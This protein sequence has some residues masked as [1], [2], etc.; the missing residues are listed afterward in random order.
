MNNLSVLTRQAFEQWWQSYGDTNNRV[1]RYCQLLLMTSILFLSLTSAGIQQLLW[2][3]ME[4][5]L[6]ADLVISHSSA[7]PAE[8]LKPLAAMSLKSSASQLMDITLTHHSQWQPVQLKV[9]DSAYPL[10]GTLRVT[11]EVGGIEV[12]A[13]ELPAAD[14]IWLDSRTFA[15]LQVNI[16]DYLT[17][18]GQR[19]RVAAI[20]TH[21]PDRLME[22]HSVDHRALVSASVS[23]N[24]FFANTEA[25]YR[26]S[27]EVETVNLTNA[28][29]WANAN[30]GYTQVL[31]ASS[32]HPLANFWKRV[33]NFFGLVMVVLFFMAAITF[34][35]SGKRQLEQ[36]L[37][38]F[39]L[40]L[41][42]GMSRRSG[43]FI[44]CGQWLIGFVT[45]VVAATSVAYCAY[46]LVLNKFAGHFA[47]LDLSK[48]TELSSGLFASLP[49][50]PWFAWGK[51][52]ALLAVLLLLF[53]AP[54]WLKLFR[55]SPAI[56]LKKSF[57]GQS[58]LIVWL[59]NTLVI[60][61]LAF[62]YS[63]N[64]LLT[65]M[66][67]SGLAA[68]LV[69]MAVVTWLFLSFG[70]KITLAR[71]SLLV[72]CLGLMKQRMSSKATQIMGLGLCITLMLFSFGLMRDF[73]SMLQR[74]TRTH[75]GNL[76]ISQV[77]QAQV[78]RLQDWADVN[79]ANI[80]VLKPYY[81]A[82]LERINGLT[83]SDAIKYPSEASATVQKPVRLHTTNALPANNTVE[84]GE[85]WN[86]GLGALGDI[87]VE[88]EVMMDLG[89]S[90]G[91]T[92]QFRLGKQRFTFTIRASHVFKA[93]RDSV[94]FWFQVPQSVAAEVAQAPMFMGSME[95]PD[96]AWPQLAELWREMPTLKML[97]LKEIAERFD[98]ILRLMQLT[99][100]LFS[101]LILLLSLL[102]VVS[103]IQGFQAQDKTRNGLMLSFGMSKRECVRLVAWE[104]LV[105]GL[106]AS[107]SAIIGT[108]LIGHLMYQSQFSMQYQVDW[109]WLLSV[110]AITVLGAIALGL[111]FSRE[112]LKVSIRQLLHEA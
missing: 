63:D 15:A 70:E 108:V 5:L 43:I 79:Q 102:V 42:F 7:I 34:S 45:S 83:L 57:E 39:S 76:M 14:E 88:S 52:V 19:L 40:F 28:I 106:I 1:L 41:S 27:F 58:P 95:L 111:V 77:S 73:S 101:A 110:T 72:F 62:F 103:T 98:N 93:G 11:H 86:P 92:L 23:L 74:Y 53:Q 48:S 38:R 29:R 89:L 47:L 97:T 37:F 60:S 21:E 104:W 22:G 64:P 12:R 9:V 55:T 66:T 6:G 51:A 36:Q 99:L 80:L 85:F 91:D 54:F 112:S 59:F 20:L 105:T 50:M 81:Y 4:Q 8:Q 10:R 65:S 13:N 94:T 75:D 33:E 82:K 61:L 67:L 100:T 56:L 78:P 2:R 24:Q 49:A 69:L 109:F 26:Y 84:S 107:T 90:L 96:N 30:L 3:N 44:W 46:A 32:G 18:A 68:S 31:H 25:M 71:S 17:V 87:S 35:L 16:G